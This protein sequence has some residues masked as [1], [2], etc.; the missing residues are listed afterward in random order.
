MSTYIIDGPT[1]IGTTGQLNE[2]LGNMRL[3]NITQQNGDMVFTDS[4][5]NLTRLGAPSAN[6]TSVLLF[7]NGS[8]AVPVWLAHGTIGDVLTVTG[9]NQIGWSNSNNEA[10]N[11]GFSSHKSGNLLLVAPTTPQTINDWSVAN[12]DVG[13]YNN[14]GIFFDNANGVFTNS[15]ANAVFQFNMGLQFAQEA[16]GNAG[17]R[18]V[19]VLKNGVNELISESFQP[20]PDNTIPRFINVGNNLRLFQND[21][22]VVQLWSSTTTNINVLAPQSYWGMER[23]SFI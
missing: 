4:I 11:F 14:A 2:I 9:A 13:E 8:G 19:R 21:N 16:G 7:N 3:S 10:S 18:F 22:V 1:T 17:T 6:I 15:G 12:T 20:T 5:N 23:L